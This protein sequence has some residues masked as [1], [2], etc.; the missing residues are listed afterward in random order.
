M[1]RHTQQ[2]LL[3]KEHVM[4]LKLTDL[5][6]LL[7]H[8]LKDLYSAETQLIQALPKMAK[9]AHSPELQKAF[10][11]HLDETRTHVD[12]LK[13]IFTQL[14]FSPTGQHCAGMEGLVEE[15]RDM[16]EEDAPSE[17]KDAGLICAA[18]RVEH[19]EI[20]GYGCARTFAKQLG[21]ENIAQ[22][23]QTTLDEE[24][25]ADKKLTKLAESRI[26]AESMALA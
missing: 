7:I 18:Q 19:Y 1:G 8:E 6:T 14:E 12:R 22:M 9:A 13:D 16:I 21:M 10:K 20:A 11:E 17:T 2:H 5:R 15:G 25:A 23:L 26:N 4:A 24:G 3:W